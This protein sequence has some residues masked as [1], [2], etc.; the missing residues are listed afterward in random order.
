[1]ADSVTTGPK[2]I[3]VAAQPSALPA[4]RR[5]LGDMP[6]VEAVF[7]D[8]EA[9]IP[10]HLGSADALVLPIYFYGAEVAAAVRAA[11]PRLKWMQLLNAGY[12]RLN[13]GNVPEGVTVSTAGDS[14]APAVAD[15][16]MSLLLA[17]VRRLP[18]TWD[19]QKTGRWNRATYEL[20][21]SLRGRS[22][23][24]LGF[25]SIGQAI[26]RRLKAFDVS[27][28]AV[29]R[30]GRAGPDADRVVSQERLDEVLSGADIL[31]IASELNDQ[32]R[33]AIDARR[34]ALL[35]KGALF[36]NIARG[37]IADTQ[38]ILS[39]LESG[40]LGAAGLD[41][42]DP[43]PLPEGHPLWT[44]PNALITSHVAGGGSNNN[45]ATFVR[46]NVE[47]LLGGQTPI[48]TVTL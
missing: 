10:Q 37:P 46:G 5:E 4:L 8:N 30:S 34:L 33:G 15:H 25:G 7:V 27:V 11:Q 48:S 13:K 1:M 18:Q 40:Q 38:A 41:V 19:S 20:S 31:V 47:R 23:V 39:A 43:E 9:A 29:N 22:A 3:V 26:A 32:T 24:V 14:L 12:D 17:L 35:A 2:R 28:T 6:G 45:V 16:A 44:A 21:G 42:T 36:V